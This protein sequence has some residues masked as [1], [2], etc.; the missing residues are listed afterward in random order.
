MELHSKTRNQETYY[1]NIYYIKWFS[2]YF[3]YLTGLLLYKLK[4][5]H[6]GADR[7]KIDRSN[8]HLLITLIYDGTNTRA[9]RGA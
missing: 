7:V 3:L 1:M 2:N 9:E 4:F 6:H 5:R 8:N